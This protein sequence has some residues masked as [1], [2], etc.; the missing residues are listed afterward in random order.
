[1]HSVE[2]LVF[3]LHASRYRQLQSSHARRMIAALIVDSFTAESADQQIT[4]AHDNATLS[5]RS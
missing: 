1:M 5:R 2:N 4:S 3:Y